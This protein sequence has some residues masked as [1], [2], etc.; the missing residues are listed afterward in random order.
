VRRA[1]AVVVIALAGCVSGGGDD[2][3]CPAT[4]GVAFQLRDP[5]TGVCESFDSGACRGIPYPDWA[6]CTGAC[7]ALDEATCIATPRCRAVYTGTISPSNLAYYG[8]WGTAPSSSLAGV[9]CWN[10]DPFQCSEDA[11]CAAVFQPGAGPP[12]T[13]ETCMP[14][15]RSFQPG[16]CDAGVTCRALPPACPAGTQPGEDGICYTGFC[17]PT[18]ACGGPL[19]PGTCNPGVCTQVAPDCPTGTVPGTSGGCWTGYCI[20]VSVCP[21]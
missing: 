20:P 3:I 12:L 11:E 10:L 2:Q 15:L 14:E 9:S 18:A 4:A 8:C 5:A 6:D 13:W 1:A 19:D 21:A 17:I 16:T 7:D